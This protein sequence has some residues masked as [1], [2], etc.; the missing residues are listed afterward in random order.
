MRHI[1]IHAP[2]EHAGSAVLADSLSIRMQI[3]PNSTDIDVVLELRV[4]EPKFAT[5]GQI[6]STFRLLSCAYS[7]LS[8]PGCPHPAP[9]KR[10]RHLGVPT[11]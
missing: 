9:A 11:A 3:D 2:R 5:N 4:L 8:S 1:P 7:E 10:F 6:T